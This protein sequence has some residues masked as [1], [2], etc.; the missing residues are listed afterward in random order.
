MKKIVLKASL[1]T[2]GALAALAIL[3]F[4]LWILISPQSMATVSEKVGNYDFA[5]TCAE[6]KF[7]YSDDTDDLARV[8]E[9]SILSGNDKKIVKYCSRLS[10]R[11]DF[12]ELC[13]H[14]DEELSHTQVGKYSANYKVYIL[15]TLATA[16]YR[17]GDL[18]KAVETA[19][20]GGN[21]DY[22]RRLIIEV[23]TNGSET[24]RQLLPTLPKDELLK[25]SVVEFI[26][27]IDNN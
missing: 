25:E 5:I 14:R 27:L 23:F 1:I 4:S 12:V 6:L 11:D 18:K 19:E 10:E 16:Q 7:K 26:A 13:R 15:G 22:F 2:L 20:K 3:V 24:D 21:I 9:D 17:T 8:A